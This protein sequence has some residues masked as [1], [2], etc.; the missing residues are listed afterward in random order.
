[1]I[2]GRIKYLFAKFQFLYKHLKK[3]TSLLFYAVR[4]VYIRVYCVVFPALLYA[5]V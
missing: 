1:M 3:N 2:R 5:R 4:P